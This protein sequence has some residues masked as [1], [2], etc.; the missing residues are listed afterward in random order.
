MSNNSCL[1]KK[2]SVG[3]KIEKKKIVHPRIKDLNPK[4]AWTMSREIKKLNKGE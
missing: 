3:C 4:S 2:Y 1:K